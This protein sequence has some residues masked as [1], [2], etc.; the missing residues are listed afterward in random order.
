MIITRTP[1]RYTIGGGGTDLPAYY[2]QH[3]G[4]VVSAAIDKYMYISVNRLIVEDLIRLKYSKSESAVTPDAIEH[5]IVRN[6]LKLVGIEKAIEISSQADVPGGTG[7]GSSSSYAVGLLTALHA[8]QRK[9]ISTQD[10]AELACHVE[11]DLCKK[12]IGKQDQYI[13][14][15]GGVTAFHIAPDGKVRVEEGVLQQSVLDV[16]E[17]NTLLFYTGMT[18]S[19]DNIL[20]E[21]KIALSKSASATG[22]YLHQIKEIGYR[23]FEALKTG[24]VTDFGLLTHEHWLV[25][26]RLST[27]IS[28]PRIN[29]LYQL[30]RDNGALGGKIT[31]AGGGGFLVVYVEEHR[32]KVRKALEGAGLRELRYRLDFDGSKVI[33]NIV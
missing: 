26:Q 17:H 2:T 9:H 21:Q 27:K 19:A 24:N 4:F 29:D 8:L 32:Q 13:A 23:I 12:P 30:A 3:G 20:G 7:L 1:L 18:R 15:H 31:G 11:I 22:E 25:K 10:L 28:D 6:T 14:A 16:L 5:D 33:A